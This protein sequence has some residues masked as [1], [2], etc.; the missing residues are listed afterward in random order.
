MTKNELMTENTILAN[1]YNILHDAL[2]KMNETINGLHNKSDAQDKI[3][4]TQAL[5]IA[6][7]KEEYVILQNASDKAE[8]KLQEAKDNL[9]KDY[10]EAVDKINE[11]KEINNSIKE[12][13]RKL[14]EKIDKAIEYIKNNV[15]NTGWL[16]IGSNCVKE[17]LEILGDKE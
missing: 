16:E 4:N 1:N 8:D 7:L 3:I 17:L 11:L 12:V 9:Q 10:Q 6:R 13:D 15:D 14:L 5:E 2:E